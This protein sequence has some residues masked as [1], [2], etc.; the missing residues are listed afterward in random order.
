MKQICEIPPEGWITTMVL[1]WD[2][3]KTLVINYDTMTL[4]SLPV[5]F[6]SYMMISN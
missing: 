1:V 2:N 6:T 4:S 3:S 5:S